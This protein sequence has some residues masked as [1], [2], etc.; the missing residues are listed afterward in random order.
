ML[1]EW[2]GASRSDSGAVRR[3]FVD[4]DMDLIVWFRDQVITD[5]QL[6]YDKRGDQHAI[7]WS[8]NGSVQ[9]RRVDAGDRPSGRAK[10][11]PVITGVASRAI[12]ELPVRFA[13]RAS[14]LDPSMTAFVTKVIQS[15]SR[16]ERGEGPGLST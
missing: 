14:E 15:F 7:T 3:W 11:S 10:S 16:G 13:N 8:D 2:L 1:T 12:E 5:F 9:H 6:C 4:D